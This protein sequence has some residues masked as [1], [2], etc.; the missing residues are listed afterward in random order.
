MQNNSSIRLNSFKEKITGLFSTGGFIAR[1]TIR[2]DG[3]PEQHA[4]VYSSTDTMWF[5]IEFERTVHRDMFT[6]GVGPLDEKRPVRH[7]G[8]SMDIHGAISNIGAS[9]GINIFSCL[10]EFTRSTFDRQRTEDTFHEYPPHD[11]N[12]ILSWDIY[13]FR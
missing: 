11:P 3:I 6:I 4:I 12:N 10:D 7:I 5:K 8:F 13:S 1:R 2:R 9:E